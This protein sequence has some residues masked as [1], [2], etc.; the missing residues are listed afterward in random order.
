M[1]TLTKPVPLFCDCEKYCKGQRREVSRST[2]YYHKN[3]RKPFSQFTPEFQKFLLG[4]DRTHVPNASSS[5][6]NPTQNT[7]S[8]HGPLKKRAHFSANES[9]LGVVGSP[10]HYVL[11]CIA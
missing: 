7:E 2:F 1:S 10:Q 11:V 5:S 4:T 3:F 6:L 8:S 9:G